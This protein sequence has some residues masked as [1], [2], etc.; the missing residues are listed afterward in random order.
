M[1]TAPDI[2]PPRPGESDDERRLREALN[3]HCG[4]ALHVLDSALGLRQ[5]SGQVQRERHRARGDLT[6]FAIRAMHSFALSASERASP[7]ADSPH[8]D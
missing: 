3:R 5:S 4:K 1:S 2:L 6:D 7:G 8:V